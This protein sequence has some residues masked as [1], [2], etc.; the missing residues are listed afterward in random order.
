MVRV[1]RGTIARKRRKNLLK[2]TKGF[3]YGRKSKYRLSKEALLHAWTN[4]FKDRKIKK[5]E[6]RK[7]WQIKINAALKAEGLKYNKFIK[8]LKDKKII[9]DR[10]VLAELAEK[11]PALFKKILENIQ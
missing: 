9:L 10:K 6:N 2:H 7:L 1:K 8:D 4:A 11:H 5:R 3:R